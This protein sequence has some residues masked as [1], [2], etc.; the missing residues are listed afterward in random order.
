VIDVIVMVFA[1][2]VVVADAAV[3]VVVVAI[4]VVTVVVCVVVVVVVVAVVGF[5]VVVVVVVVGFVV[6]VVVLFSVFLFLQQIC[7]KLLF[8]QSMKSQNFGSFL[9]FFSSNLL[10]IKPFTLP[11]TKLDRFVEVLKGC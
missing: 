5:L 6:V 1:V 3:F 2:N 9:F 10:L 11:V 8:S 7:L 4:V